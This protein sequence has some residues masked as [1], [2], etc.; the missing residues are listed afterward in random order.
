[1]AIEASA[2][3]NVL[4]STDDLRI[5][6]VA[7]SFEAEVPFLREIGLAADYRPDVPFFT[8]AIRRLNLR[9]SDIVCCIFAN[10]PLIRPKNL[11]GR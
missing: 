7:T 1:V 5:S 6:K 2:F 8:D 10:A 3:N 9:S 11:L 4:L